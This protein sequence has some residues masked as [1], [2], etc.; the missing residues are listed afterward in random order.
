MKDCTG[1]REK[2]SAF[3]DHELG[4]GDRNL[5]EAHLR[6]CLACSKE[7]DSLRKLNALMDEVP[8]P[9]PDPLFSSRTVYRVSSWRR[10]AY[11][12]EHFYRPA[13]S[14]L[15]TGVSL[16]VGLYSPDRRSPAH[17]YLRNFDDFP[18]ESF[19]SVYV[20]LIQGER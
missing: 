1:I 7:A 12:K 19:S 2:L 16:I 15:R 14:F 4:T 5:I 3:I 20:S 13:A 6:H 9:E 11:V 18:P 8:A 10:C 17:G